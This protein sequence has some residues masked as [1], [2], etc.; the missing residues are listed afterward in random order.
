MLTSVEAVVLETDGNFS[1]VL[2]VGGDQSAL[3]GQGQPEQHQAVSNVKK[4]A[5]PGWAVVLQHLD[6]G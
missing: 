6:S 3:T 1:V 4:M 5:A 2:G